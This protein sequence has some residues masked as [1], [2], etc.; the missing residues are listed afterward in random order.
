MQQTQQQIELC[1]HLLQDK[2]QIRLLL[3]Q[4]QQLMAGR[5]YRQ[6][7]P[8][9]LPRLRGEAIAFRKKIGHLRMLFRCHPPP[10]EQQHILNP[11]IR[12]TLRI[13]FK[14]DNHVPTTSPDPTDKP[15]TPHLFGTIHTPLQSGRA[16]LHIS[17]VPHACKRQLRLLNTPD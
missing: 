7:S 8:Q 15:P 11:G 1:I 17:C 13:G 14:V 5:Q 4:L 9:I 10:G 16:F 2:R 3:P 12:P 6:Q